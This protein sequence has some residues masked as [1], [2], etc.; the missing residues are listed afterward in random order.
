VCSVPSLNEEEGN[1]RA[2]VIEK[3][4]DTAQAIGSLRLKDDGVRGPL[5]T[6]PRKIVEDA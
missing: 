6:A 4:L 1:A 3:V 5:G 2:P